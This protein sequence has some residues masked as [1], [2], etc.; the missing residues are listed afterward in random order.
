M[1]IAKSLPTEKAWLFLFISIYRR[2][3]GLTSPWSWNPIRNN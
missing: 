2:S 1:L 3:S